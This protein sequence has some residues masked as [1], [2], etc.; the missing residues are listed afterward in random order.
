MAGLLARGMSEAEIGRVLL[1]R[2]EA[3]DHLMRT[4]TYCES[5]RVIGHCFLRGGWR[6]T[7]RFAVITRREGRTAWGVEHDVVTAYPIP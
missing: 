6:P 3:T 7:R 2:P 4:L 1:H 5:T